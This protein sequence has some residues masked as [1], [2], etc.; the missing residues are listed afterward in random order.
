MNLSIILS[1]YLPQKLDEWRFFATMTTLA[2]PHGNVL[3]PKKIKKKAPLKKV[4]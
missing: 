3:M 4:L 1:I 2:T